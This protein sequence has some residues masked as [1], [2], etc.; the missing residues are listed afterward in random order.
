MDGIAQQ[1]HE[2]VAPLVVLV[3]GHRVAQ[4]V[5]RLDDPHCRPSRPEQLARRRRLE[6]DRHVA[7][8]DRFEPR[9]GM[10]DD[11]R[12]HRVGEAEIVGGGHA[13]DEDANLVAARHGVDHRLWAGG[14]GLVG[15]FIM[16]RLVIEAAVDPAQFAG[17]AE[18]LES[19]IDCVSPPEIEKIAGRPDA[20]RH[21][22]A[23]EDGGFQSGCGHVHVRNM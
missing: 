16:R 9:L 3:T 8:L 7:E 18:P 2:P 22:C 23:I 14:I 17:L 15:Q 4:P 6:N 1:L 21:G 20:A 12:R 13:I 10:D 19:L 11:L 5:Q